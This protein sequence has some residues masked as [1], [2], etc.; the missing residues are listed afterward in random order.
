[1]GEDQA[2]FFR[3]RTEVLAVLVFSLTMGATAI[4]LAIGRSVRARSDEPNDSLGVMQGALLGFMALV[5]AFGL[6]LAVGRYENRRARDGGGSH[7]VGDDLVA[8]PDLGRAGAQRVA[9]PA[10]GLHRP[11]DPYHRHGAGHWPPAGGG[12]N[13]RRGRAA[14]VAVG[15]AGVGLRARGQRPPVVC[16]GSQ[17]GHRCPGG[18]RSRSRQPGADPGDGSRGPRGGVGPGPVGGAPRGAGPGQR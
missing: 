17:R 15:R 18:T 11:R 9:R 6:S 5:L 8:G 4:G 14:A 7:R 13:E 10:G 3:L 2:V 16:R 1:M 12:G